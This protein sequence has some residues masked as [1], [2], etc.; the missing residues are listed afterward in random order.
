MKRK[1]ET[2]K[3]ILFLIQIVLWHSPKRRHR[4]ASNC[5]KLLNDGTKENFTIF[6]CWNCEQL[7]FFSAFDFFLSVSWHQ[8]QWRQLICIDGFLENF[9]RRVARRW[10]IEM[11]QWK[12][13]SSQLFQNTLSC[14]RIIFLEMTIFCKRKKMLT[15]LQKIKLLYHKNKTRVCNK[16]IK[17]F[18]TT[19]C[20]HGDN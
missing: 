9:K 13:F 14:E 1:K 3:L 2:N 16:F 17:E 5:L 18:V 6:F 10:K 20:G 8:K 7:S 4:I 11:W 19:W 12:L 15:I